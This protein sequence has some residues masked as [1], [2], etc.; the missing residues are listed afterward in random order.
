MQ[1]IF[2]L[3]PLRP[4]DLL[5]WFKVLCAL[6]VCLCVRFVIQ[7]WNIPPGLCEV[8]VIIQVW[9]NEDE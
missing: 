5:W 8:C 4:S 9:N 3:N 6:R 7:F 2:S 1:S